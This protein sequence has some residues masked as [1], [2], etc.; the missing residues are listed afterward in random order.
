MRQDSVMLHRVEDSNKRIEIDTAKYKINEIMSVDL[1]S[2]GFQVTGGRRLICVCYRRNCYAT[3]SNL[4]FRG[5]ACELTQICNILATVDLTA[6]S[7]QYE[8]TNY[9]EN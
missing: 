3:F 4:S 7:F 8:T 9:L 6:D 2:C 1:I 5:E